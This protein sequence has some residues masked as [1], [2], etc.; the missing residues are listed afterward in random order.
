MAKT[1]SHGSSSYR[2]AVSMVA[3]T[4]I[5]RSATKGCPGLIGGH[6]FGPELVPVAAKRIEI[7]APDLHRPEAS[8]AGR[9]LEVG[10]V[11]R[12]R[13]EDAAPR[14]DYLLAPVGRAELLNLSGHEKVF[15]GLTAFDQRAIAFHK[16]ELV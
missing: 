10:V 3:S 15:Y 16:F 14:L 9:I 12:G 13:R 8:V 4:S 11:I 7:N 1:E 6:G 5:S 2:F